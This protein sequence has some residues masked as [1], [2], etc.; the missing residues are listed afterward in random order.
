MLSGVHSRTA[1]D[2]APIRAGILNSER[3]ARSIGTNV[4]SRLGR[5]DHQSASEGDALHQQ[6]GPPGCDF[7]GKCKAAYS[8][9]AACACSTEEV[10][11]DG[12]VAFFPRHERFL[13]NGERGVERIV[14][15][16]QGLLRPSAYR[17]SPYAVDRRLYQGGL[18]CDTRSRWVRRLSTPLG[19][20]SGNSTTFW[21]DGGDPTAWRP[22]VATYRQRGLARVGLW[23]DIFIS[24]SFLRRASEG[25]PRT[26][27]PNPRA[28]RPRVRGAPHARCHPPERDCRRLE[29]NLSTF[30]RS[31]TGSEWSTTCGL[32]NWPT[33]WLRGRR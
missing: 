30:A 13:V 17:E 21:N 29:G 8:E 25:I 12:A 20:A 15:L 9:S 2:V 32:I 24:A 28:F 26:S 19:G 23:P 18:V 27:D 5:S 22:T 7:L 1:V 16:F 14:E 11:G 6:V 4:H 10:G 31:D 3:R 33:F